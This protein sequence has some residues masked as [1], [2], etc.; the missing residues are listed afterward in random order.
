MNRDWRKFAPWGLYLALA[1]A[2]VSFGLFVVF[3]SFDLPL[4]ISLALVVVGLG[5]SILLDPERARRFLTG[6]QARYGSNA[7]L[8]SLAFIG[9]VVVLNYL[10]YQHPVRK[11]LTED[12][13]YTLS[14]ETVDTLQALPGTVTAVGFFTARTPSDQA[15]RLLEQYRFYGDG[16][17]EFRIVDPES[18]PVAARQA[19]I[20]RDGSIVLRLGEQ[21]E[22]VDF[23]SE[24]Q[25]TSALVRL[26]NP[27][28]RTVYFLTGHGEY[29][30]EQG[31]EQSYSLVRRTLENKNYTI[32][33]LNLL[34]DHQVPED[35]DVV[36]VA[37]PQY[38]LTGEE[39]EALAAYAEQGGAL[40]VLEEPLPVTQ[41]GAETDPLAAYLAETW[42][43]TLGRD[44]VVDLSNSSQV[45]VA[46][47]AQYGVHPITEK[48]AQVATIFPTARS[49]QISSDLTDTFS[50]LLVQT[51]QNSWAE[52]DLQAVVAQQ[53]FDLDE[54][55]LPGPVPLAAASEKAASGARLVVFGD[56]DFASDAYF[57]FLGDGDLFV[58]A[59]DW[60]AGQENLISL[61]PHNRTQRILVPPQ[62]WALGLVLLGVVF[63]LPGVALVAGLLA[64]LQR[65]RRG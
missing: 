56:S 32:H 11:D 57:A 38:P 60:A 62:S 54:A 40:L 14:P 2:L 61:T 65:R 22:I 36:V 26:M 13:Q 16:K 10:V 58:N 19:G 49:V 20:T 55:D 28:R 8:M 44:I 33:A 37:G 21:Q 52:S 34:A 25:L 23:A 30:L 27:A 5:A 50:T 47:A 46:V 18:D 59:V 35:A 48:V 1:A 3:R 42:G 41:F 53:G 17:F 51:G 39:T 43:V 15:E 7:L 24:Q 4:Q 31:G 45:F 63:L 64:W 9:I 12:R 29:D 6:R